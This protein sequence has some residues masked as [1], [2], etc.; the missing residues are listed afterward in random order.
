MLDKADPA[1]ADY[2]TFISSSFVKERVAATLV[3]AAR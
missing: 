1:T 2:N 3:S